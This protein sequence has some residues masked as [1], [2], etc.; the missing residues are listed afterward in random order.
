[1]LR[2]L[3]VNAVALRDEFRQDIKDVELLRALKSTDYVLI[4][5]DRRITTRVIEATELRAARVTSLFL[6]PFWDRLDLWQGATWLVRR[7]PMIERLESGSNA[8][9][10]GGPLVRNTVRFKRP[11]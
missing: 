5:G 9:T 1:M 6:A 11:A 3:D 7:W 4:T 8:G 10:S 2:A